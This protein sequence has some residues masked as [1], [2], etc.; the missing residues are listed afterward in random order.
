MP[1]QDQTQ[2]GRL[3]DYNALG[4]LADSSN[5]LEVI[6]QHFAARS[7]GP[8]SRHA[9]ELRHEVKFRGV[10]MVDSFIEQELVLA[11]VEFTYSAFMASEDS[12]VCEVH[13][14]FM[15]IYGLKMEKSAVSLDL[16]ALFAELHGMYHAWPYIRELV[17][18]LVSR[19]GLSGVFLPVWP[20]PKRLPPKGEYVVVRAG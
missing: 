14:A 12:A 4:P 15:V 10:P 19:M 17:G 11:S 2:S 6:P 13:G 9:G 5:L 1:S 16:I 3:I 20:P 7:N 8:L 18:S